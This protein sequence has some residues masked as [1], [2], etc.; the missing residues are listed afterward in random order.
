MVLSN[1]ATDKCSISWYYPHE[2]TASELKSPR[3]MLECV[4]V[5]HFHNSDSSSNAFSR[6][7]RAVKSSRAP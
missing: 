7:R 5:P 4:V 1:T 2:C 3:S 6:P